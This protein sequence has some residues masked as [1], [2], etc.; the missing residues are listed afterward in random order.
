MASLNKV[1]LM[2]NLTRD[3]EVRYIPSGAAVADMRLAVN[4]RYKTQQGEDKEESCFVNISAW[5]RTAETCGKYLSKGSQVLVEGRLKYDEW[6]KEGQKQSRLSVVAERVQFLDSPRRAQYG[7]APEGGGHDSEGGGM[8]RDT[9]NK[10]ADP[11]AEDDDD[12]PF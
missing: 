6:E 7:D 2:G 8:S 10:Q 11:A 3:P 4:R 1:M 9:G 5:G 12:L